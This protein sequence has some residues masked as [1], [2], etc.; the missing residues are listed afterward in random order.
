MKKDKKR[1]LQEKEMKCTK[2]S[3]RV[4]AAGV[5]MLLFLMTAVWNPG[6][7][8]AADKLEINKE[9][10][11]YFD[12]SSDALLYEFQVP[13]AG[14][15]SIKIKNADPVGEER[16]GAELYDSNNLAL[17]QK[18]FGSNVELPLY[19]TDANR[20]F[21][22]KIVKDYVSADTKFNLTIG[23]Q[24]TKDWESENND[25]AETADTITAGKK[26]YGIIDSFY[27]AC[28][29]FKF[30]LNSNKKVRITFGPKEV[31]GTWSVWSVYLIDSK[32]QS[33]EI[34]SDSA[35]QSYD[36][37]LK[38]GTYYLK[39]KHSLGVSNIP[40]ELTFKESALKL[41]KPT[42]SSIGAVGKQGLFSNW[43][44]LDPI[45][46]KNQGDATG[47]TV[48]VARK[49]N[50]TGVLGTQDIDFKN[51]NTK[52]QVTLDAQIA[53]LKSYYVQARSYVEDPFGVKIYGKYG[54]V[55]CKTLKGSMYAKLA[56]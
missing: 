32:N 37:Y 50:M 12:N 15:I 14:N 6:T 27:D 28:D 16:I 5:F 34:Y 7:V 26:L 56:K 24:P 18:H 49:K 9:Y 20:T 38:K 3:R 52:K 19:S 51:T 43:I 21:Y 48:K 8:K 44:E 42:I 47:Y 25:S 1:V 23:F 40:Y 36:C 4:W 35:K 30:K 11:I 39:V 41:E 13:A 53:V 22:L 2:Y 33:V 46:I 54:S 55:K 31:T 45:R 17:T 29:Y 10:S